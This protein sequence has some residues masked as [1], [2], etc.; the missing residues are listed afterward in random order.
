M[1][2]SPSQKERGDR[3]RMRRDSATGQSPEEA[4]R[5]RRLIDLGNHARMLTTRSH[6]QALWAKR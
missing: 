1:T 4:S 6:R 5:R 2:E 3:H